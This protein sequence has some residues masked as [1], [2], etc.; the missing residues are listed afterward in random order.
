MINPDRF[1]GYKN[2]SAYIGTAHE[3]QEGPILHSS[4]W[5]QR[6]DWW[7]LTSRC[8][9]PRPLDRSK[10]YPTPTAPTSPPF[11]WWPP[12]FPSRPPRTRTPGTPSNFRRSTRS[13]TSGHRAGW[14]TSLPFLCVCGIASSWRCRCRWQH[15]LTICTWAI[16]GWRSSVGCRT[17]R[18]HICSS[19]LPYWWCPCLRILCIGRFRACAR[20]GPPYEQA[21][22]APYCRGSFWT[23][24]PAFPICSPARGK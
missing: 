9:Y 13:G 23:D 3:D 2:P 17:S 10:R 1:W 21:A 4:S 8:R 14:S 11:S 6:K 24:S 16:V 20:R 12:F 19:I 7:T 5:Q 18:T 22:L 15:S